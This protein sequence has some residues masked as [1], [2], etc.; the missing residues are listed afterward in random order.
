MKP[1]K[2]TSR[3]KIYIV[4]FYDAKTDKPL[5]HT[6]TTEPMTQKQANDYITQAFKIGL[7]DSS[8]YGLVR[9]LEQY[10]DNK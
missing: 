3:K 4:V 1:R 9:S 7:Y 10:E 2:S 8:A 6:K 5:G